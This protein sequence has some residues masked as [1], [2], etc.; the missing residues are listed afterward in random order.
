MSSEAPNRSGENPYRNSNPAKAA[1]SAVPGAY[2]PQQRGWH[3][4]V[5]GVTAYA[6][7]EVTFIILALGIVFFF[8]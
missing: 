1:V 6:I 4:A 5:S 2:A 3:D 8:R 7:A